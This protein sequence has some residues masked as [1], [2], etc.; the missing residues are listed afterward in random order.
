MAEMT[1]Q[2]AQ[3][4][5]RQYGDSKASP[6]SFFKDVVK[7][8]DTLRVGNLDTTELGVSKLPVRTYEELALFS[9]EVANQPEW[10]TYFTKM[11]KIQTDS[12]LSK[13]GFL[14]KQINTTKKELADVTAK[15][16]ENKGWFK[17]K[18]EESPNPTG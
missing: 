8:D 3:E 5:L 6:A 4:L 12:S 9:K 11:S 18:K 1:E 17:G 16:K 2:E 10:A 13:E 15:P 14:L 7:T